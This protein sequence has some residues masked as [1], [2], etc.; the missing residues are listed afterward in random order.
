MT[1]VITAKS[2]LGDKSYALQVRAV[3]SGGGT[4]DWGP[5]FS[6]L[7]RNISSAASVFYP[8]TSSPA[9]IRATWSGTLDQTIGP[10]GLSLYGEQWVVKKSD[11]PITEQ[12]FDS[13]GEVVYRGSSASS[14]DLDLNQEPVVYLAVV[15]MDKFGNR[16]SIKTQSLAFTTPTPPPYISIINTSGGFKVRFNTQLPQSNA[17]AHHII[18]IL[19]NQPFTS[20][21]VISRSKNGFSCSVDVSGTAPLVDEVVQVSIGDS[22][23]DGI[24]RVRSVIGTSVTYIHEVSAVVPYA[25]LTIPGY[26]IPTRTGSDEGSEIYRNDIVASSPSI[27]EFDYVPAFSG[28]KLYVA[29]G[30]EDDYS[31]RST[32]TI[33]DPSGNVAVYG[34]NFVADR[35][36]IALVST[37]NKVADSYWKYG[38]IGWKGIHSTS[39]L[40]LNTAATAGVLKMD[41]VTAD[42]P[43]S[44]RMGVVNGSSTPMAWATDPVSVKSDSQS[45]YYPS[46]VN[47]AAVT[48]SENLSH[49]IVDDPFYAP[50]DGI[51]KRTSDTWYDLHP[52]SGSVKTG[53]GVIWAECS[54]SSILDD[55]VKTLDPILLDGSTNLTGSFDVTPEAWGGSTDFPTATLSLY[56]VASDWAP[57]RAG[58]VYDPHYFPIQPSNTG[59]AIT[60]YNAV[61]N[62]S[63]SSTTCSLTLATGMTNYPNV[64]ES[65]TVSIADSNF[66][67]IWIVATR[68]ANIITYVTLSSATVT[69]VAATGTVSTNLADT[70]VITN[71]EKLGT[72]VKLTISGTIFPTAGDVVDVAMGNLGIDGSNFTLAVETAGAVIQYD[73]TPSST[74]TAAAGAGYVTIRRTGKATQSL[75]D[76]WTISKDPDQGFFTSA[77]VP[78]TKTLNWDWAAPGSVTANQIRLVWVLTF[79]EQ[80]FLE[81]RAGA[82]SWVAGTSYLL[83]LKS[84]AAWP[85]ANAYANT[86]ESNSFSD[87]QI[88]NEGASFFGDSYF[89]DSV[90][91]GGDE[92]LSGDLVTDGDIYANNV[93]IR[94]DLNLDTGK[95]FLDGDLNLTSG[96][97]YFL[98]DDFPI[99][100]T[101]GAFGSTLKTVNSIRSTTDFPLDTSNYFFIVS[102][103]VRFTGA[104]TGGSYS[105]GLYR[106]TGS[107][108]ARHRQVAAVTNASG[109]VGGTIVH[110]GSAPS[111]VRP[112]FMCTVNGSGAS[113]TSTYTAGDAT[114]VDDNRL[115]VIYWPMSRDKQSSRKSQNLGTSPATSYSTATDPGDVADP[116]K[117]TKSATMKLT[118]G[119]KNSYKGTGV[120]NGYTGGDLIQGYYSSLNGNQKAAWGF[121]GA[122]WTN[123]TGNN[124]TG[125]SASAVKIIG[126]TV[127]V[128]STHWASFSGGTL[129]VGTHNDPSNGVVSNYSN[130]SAKT[131][132]R[133]RAGFSGTVTKDVDLGVNIGKEI[134][135][136]HTR[137]HLP[138]GSTGTGPVISGGGNTQGLIFGPGPTSASQYYGSIAPSYLEITLKVQW[139]E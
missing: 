109:V 12:N 114:P 14:L 84:F 69:S 128:K 74:I 31:N 126:C 93:N 56:A 121:G 44:I 11:S 4:G 18:K 13:N 88:F 36:G 1:A 127:R 26:L 73:Q 16:S 136:A 77:L 79:S 80:S 86:G 49:A 117:K 7:K 10:D 113:V 81:S 60:K 47:N 22:R 116:T 43:D 37:S 20:Y 28:Q 50:T 111:T 83:K 94:G 123:A 2:L 66:D 96:D 129:I 108:W 71:R 131:V 6:I 42:T 8:I 72:R 57:D 35:D 38:Y 58:A 97:A 100:N 59:R 65:I 40:D 62:K 90:S 68:S 89:A 61:T 75:I 137:S 103:S 87:P 82:S 15:A 91:I 119:W 110:F 46:L 24:Y 95:M 32:W 67:G 106:W 9:G 125:A 21:S 51:L 85:G 64:G 92:F 135:N 139:K 19:Y 102:W 70:Y 132:D 33:S 118:G 29:V 52:S 27:T 76:S 120:T 55:S 112:E 3:Y 99:N 98:T 134:W 39:T 54:A 78:K 34:R 138:A 101:G 23:F 104:A 133:I 124:M 17:N 5:T 53:L 105:F 41:V 48:S 30:T 45:R 63:K 122:Q 107:N 130:I 115:Q 25:V